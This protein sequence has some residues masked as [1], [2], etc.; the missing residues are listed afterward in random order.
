MKPN[1]QAFTLIEL[2]V[3]VLIIGILAAVAL[4]QYQ[5][6]VEK[7]HLAEA[8][9]LLNTMIQAQESYFLANGTYAKTADELDISLPLEPYSYG[10]NPRLRNNYFDFGFATDNPQPNIIAF[11]QRWENG[12]VGTQQN[13]TS[14][15]YYV[16]FRIAND[17]NLYCTPS[18][19]NL[20]DVYQICQSLSNGKTAV[21]ANGRTYYVVQ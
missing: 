20:G 10:D 5:K 16:L 6:A 2:L 3:V 11:A 7:A 4:P 21:S 12:Q 8:F 14:P 17:P 9:T 15:A 18:Q 1:N 13:S 19:T